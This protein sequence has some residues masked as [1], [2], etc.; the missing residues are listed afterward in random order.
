M[1]PSIFREQLRRTWNIKLNPSQLGSLVAFFDLDGDGTV[2]CAEF[3]TQFFK[4]SLY[5][6]TAPPLLPVLR[7][8]WA[9]LLRRPS[10]MRFPRAC[11]HYSYTTAT[12]TTTTA[13]A[14]TA[15][16]TN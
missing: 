13:A 14:A 10:R 4:T 12:A 8:L 2:D 3:L 1:T 15:T 9:G 5:V 6:E 16:T 7:L 11:C